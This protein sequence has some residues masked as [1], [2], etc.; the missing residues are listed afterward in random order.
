MKKLGGLGGHRA[1]IPE[2]RGTAIM[3]QLDKLREHHRELGAA[4]AALER[5]ARLG[6]APVVAIDSARP[7]ACG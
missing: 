4:I 7:R 5:L 6:P 1:R 2:G 3:T